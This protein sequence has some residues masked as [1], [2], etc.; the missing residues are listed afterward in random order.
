MMAQSIKT[1]PKTERERG[2]D[3]RETVEEKCFVKK[4][5]LRQMELLQKEC[6]ECGSAYQRPHTMVEISGA[7]AE[8]AN[9]Y[10]GIGANSEEAVKDD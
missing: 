1:T 2:E 4:T 10:A 6:E 7:L 3:V 8:L 9:A 5:L